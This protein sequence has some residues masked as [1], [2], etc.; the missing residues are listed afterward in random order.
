V[1]YREDNPADL[2]RARAAVAEWREANP[3]GTR[4]QLVAD[5]G[6]RFRAGYGVVLRGV[7]SA[8]DRD[9]SR[10]VPGGRP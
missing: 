5:L 10:Q 7:L 2:A 4:E 6:P 1:R 3:D 8:V 9:R